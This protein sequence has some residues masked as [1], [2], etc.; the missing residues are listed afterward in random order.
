MKSSLENIGPIKVQSPL[1]RATLIV[2]ALLLGIAVVA[3]FYL[4]RA[5]RTSD[6][7]GIWRMI[8]THD[9]PNYIPMMEQFDKVLRSGVFYPRW[10]P[11]FN[12]GYGSATANFYPPGSLYLTSLINSVVNSWSITLFI[13]SALSLGVSCIAFYL[14]SRNF[15]SPTASAVAAV[16]Y[17]VLPYHQLD[18]YWRGAIPEFVGFAFLPIVL[19]FAYKLGNKSQFRYYAGLGFFYGLYLLTHMPVGYLFTYTLALYAVLW[20]IRERNGGIALRI[21]AGMGIGLM[22]SAVYW[23]PAALEG[24][25]AYEWASEIFPYHLSYITM[26]PV[27]DAFDKH[28]QGIFSYNAL[29][30]IVTIVTLITLSKRAASSTTGNQD[31]QKYPE[32]HPQT[33]LWLILGIAT[34]F[35]ATSFSIYISRLIPKIQI[36]VPPFRWLAISSVF[37]SLLIA[38]TIDCLAKEGTFRHR[39]ELAY[40]TALVLVIALNVWLTAHGIIFG[41]LSRPTQTA[42]PGSSFID[43]GFTPKNSTRPAEIPNTP[44]VVVTP[45]G[46]A[47]EILKW[48]PTHR[49]IAVRVE[50]PSD[51]RI[52]TYNFPGW[53]ARLDGNVVPLLS[54][55]DGAQ[56]VAVPPGIHNIQISCESTLPRTT[57]ALLSI[58]GFTMVLGLTVADRLRQRVSTDDTTG[59][60]PVQQSPAMGGAA[61]HKEIDGPARPQFRSLAIIGL[62]IVAGVIIMIVTYRHSDPSAPENISSSRATNPADARAGVDAQ[63]TTGVNSQL[64]LPGKAAIELGIDQKAMV[65]LIA[66]ISSRDQAAVDSLVESGRVL[67]VNNNTRVQVI[68]NNAGQARVRILE[69]T[70]VMRE[71]WVPERW[72]R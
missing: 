22:V 2:S 57:G 65:E 36:A 45:D 60:A 24:K 17:A 13:L 46:G 72:I 70:Y 67:R 66:A 6:G 64:Y 49:D 40:K 50:Q 68:E 3:P 61:G 21:A 34:P 37:T 71:G 1:M 20:A 54:D 55:P 27:L 44:S 18:L 69:G 52:K 29:A 30:L 63:K 39:Y 31:Q 58:L 14:L 19:H 28:V 16:L 38:A 42:T 56:Q 32:L 5:E 23:L 43:S 25:Y 12:G 4:A 8:T 7:S 15:Y 53:T 51:V 48:L 33:R 9:L 47:T 62:V 35:M 11:D 10:T 26:L 41:A 59:I